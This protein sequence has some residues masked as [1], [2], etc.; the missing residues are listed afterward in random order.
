MLNYPHPKSGLIFS[1]KKRLITWQIFGFAC[2]GEV[3]LHHGKE[4]RE[5]NR[6]RGRTNQREIFEWALLKKS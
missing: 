2:A 5:V 4:P 6:K 3:K 1:W